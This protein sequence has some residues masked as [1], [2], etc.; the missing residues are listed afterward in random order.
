MSASQSSSGAISS[1]TSFTTFNTKGKQKQTKS[2]ESKRKQTK[3]NES[4]RKQTERNESKQ[5]AAMF[6]FRFILSLSVQMIVLS[7]QT[8]TPFWFS[9]LTFAFG[10]HVQTPKK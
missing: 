2:N 10:S 5:T 6:G 1:S 4:K 9:F 8:G 7:K 3:A